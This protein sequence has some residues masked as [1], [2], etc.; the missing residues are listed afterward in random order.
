MALA[1][2]YYTILEVSAQATPEEIKSAY[3]KFVLRWHPDKNR[4]SPEAEEMFKQGQE[5]YSVLK[6]TAKRRQYNLTTSLTGDAGQASNQSS[7]GKSDFG[8]LD[9]RVEDH[10]KKIKTDIDEM[11]RSHHYAINKAM[12]KYMDSMYKSAGYDSG[13]KSIDDHHISFYA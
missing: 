2:D 10:L 6:D 4:N 9:S 1:K 12:R 8:N 5:A 7:F 13:N 3:R 11:S